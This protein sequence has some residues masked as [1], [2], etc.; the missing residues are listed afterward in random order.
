[1]KR[2]REINYLTLKEEEL[3][4]FNISDNEYDETEKVQ[5]SNDNI[6]S[7]LRAIADIGYKFN[8]DT[9]TLVKE[10]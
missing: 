1:M 4:A 3:R 8:R 5:I 10:G 7:L 2:S 9:E 6:C